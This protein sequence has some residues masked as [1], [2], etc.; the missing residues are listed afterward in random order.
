[1]QASLLRYDC[2]DHLVVSIHSTGAVVKASLRYSLQPEERPKARQA[3]PFR[4]I[5]CEFLPGDFD[6][7]KFRD[8]DLSFPVA[9]EPPCKR[10]LSYKSG[11]PPRNH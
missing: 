1:M 5:E 11:N 6:G 9:P 8:S 10:R 7:A 3:T 4:P 2:D